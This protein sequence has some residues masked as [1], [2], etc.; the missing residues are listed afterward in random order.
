MVMPKPYTQLHHVRQKIK[1][2]KLA[3]KPTQPWPVTNPAIKEAETIPIGIAGW[4]EKF[5]LFILRAL[6]SRVL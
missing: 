2:T 4:S 3:P 6:P 5:N 1:V